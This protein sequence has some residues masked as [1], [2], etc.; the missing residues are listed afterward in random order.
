MNTP[1]GSVG[2]LWDLL[3]KVHFTRLVFSSVPMMPTRMKPCDTSIED[4]RQP[5]Q[6][7]PQRCFSYSMKSVRRA[8]TLNYSLEPIQLCLEGDHKKGLLWITGQACRSTVET[9]QRLNQ[10][11]K[12]FSETWSPS[13]LHSPFIHW[14]GRLSEFLIEQEDW[15][16]QKSARTKVKMAARFKFLIKMQTMTHAKYANCVNKQRVKKRY[17]LVI[18]AEDVVQVVLLSFI[19]NQR[20]HL[21]QR[22]NIRNH[23]SSHTE[24]EHTHT[25]P[26]VVRSCECFLQ[27][28]WRLSCRRTVL[29]KRFGQ[30][31]I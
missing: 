1:S 23:S 12:R 27:T 13:P 30:S 11:V 16:C 8:S 24:P 29:R 3:V 20:F 9:D 26:R 22:A 28:W 19:F 7:L 18:H 5:E 10:H 21:Q 4:K 6:Q 2:S 17:S 31:L 15:R 14:D 25:L